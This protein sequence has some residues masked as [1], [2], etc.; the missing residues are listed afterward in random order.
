MAVHHTGANNTELPPRARRIPSSSASLIE[1]RGTTS[2]CAENTVGTPRCSLAR[3]NY[4]RVRGEY[5]PGIQ[6]RQRPGELPPRAR[7]IRMAKGGDQVSTGTTSACAENTPPGAGRPPARGNYLRVRGEY[8][9]GPDRLF[10]NKELPP[11]ARRIRWGC[12]QNVRIAGTTSACAEN[13]WLCYRRLSRFR[14]YLRVR[15]EYPA[16]QVAMC[17][18]SELPPRAR[19]I[20]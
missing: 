19:R 3:W 4:L 12:A 20:P 13:T 10:L 9:Y 1:S 7:R 18:V 14:N 2:A 8:N 16:G 17:A 6:P 15:G 11:R 5:R